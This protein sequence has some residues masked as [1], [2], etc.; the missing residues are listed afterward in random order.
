MTP[1]DRFDEMIRRPLNPELDALLRDTWLV[2]AKVLR[3][4][5]T[6]A[7]EGDLW[8]I[9][10]DIGEDDW[11]MVL[12]QLNRMFPPIPHRLMDEAYDRLAARAVVAEQE[13]PTVGDGPW[14][15]VV[16]IDTGGR[17]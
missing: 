10:P 13:A 3:D 5:V 2:A 1:D 7:V 12:A 4:Q 9:Y 14:E 15:S 17:T 8:G 11:M 6:Q 16:S